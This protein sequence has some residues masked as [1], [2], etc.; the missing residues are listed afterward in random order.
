MLLNL[1]SLP[2]PILY[3]P[4]IYDDPRYFDKLFALW[5]DIQHLP[6]SQLDIAIDFHYCEFLGHNG[7]AFLGGLI[8]LIEFRG[9]RV[10]FDWESLPRK[11]H[12]NLAQ[13]GFL[14]DFGCNLNPWDGNSIPYRCDLQHEPNAIADYLR[15]KW[16]GK[17]WVNI[18]PALQEAITGQT[19]EIYL[20]AFEHSRSE[21][22][23]FS[24]GQHYP[25]M[26]VLQLTVIDFGIGIP[27]SVRSLPMNSTK[28]ATEA[29]TWAFL[30][31]NTTKQDDI[32]GGSGLSLLQEF[33]TK[34]HGNL[35]IFSNDG[36]VTIDDNGMRCEDKCTNFSGALV[37]IAFGCDESYYCLA[38]EISDFEKPWF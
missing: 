17:G 10:T 30:P 26:G 12:M 23:V 20:N 37:N 27:N 7:V 18:S 4:T 36:C 8:R 29:L 22:G 3:V 2:H 1:P 14:C 35:M 31:G 34:N 11:I 28:S 21:I 25:Y 5:H 24:C 33:V 38:S 9:G 32:C 16:L 6:E 15:Y 13:N 19:S